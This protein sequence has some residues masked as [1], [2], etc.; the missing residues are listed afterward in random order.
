MTKH[1][2]CVLRGEPTRPRCSEAYIFTDDL[3]IGKD[4]YDTCS[5]VVGRHGFIDMC[6]DCGANAWNVYEKG[7]Q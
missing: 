3:K 2:R 7:K 5:G 1:R 4:T 6:K